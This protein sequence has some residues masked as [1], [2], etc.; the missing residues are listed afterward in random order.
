MTGPTLGFEQWQRADPSDNRTPQAR[1]SAARDK[2]P[3]GSATGRLEVRVATRRAYSEP[4]RHA[5][6]SRVHDL[7][8]LTSWMIS[9]PGAI[10]SLTV[11]PTGS[12]KPRISDL[13]FPPLGYFQNPTSSF[14]ASGPITLLP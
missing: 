10:Y 11:V 8:D 9:G 14:E 5:C 12:Y 13:G 4:G 7:V 6:G 2:A 3:W 1:N